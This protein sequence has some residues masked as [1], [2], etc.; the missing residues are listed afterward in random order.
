MNTREG[1]AY[2]TC[3][4]GY[5]GDTCQTEV[6]CAERPCDILGYGGA[7]IEERG[8]GA[9]GVGNGDEVGGAVGV[10]DAVSGS[11]R[12]KYRCDCSPGYSGLNCEKCAVGF[13]K[14]LFACI[15]K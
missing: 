7:C 11:K 5:K 3:S 4:N 8:G 2:C 9:V 13:A 15:P 10:G 6:T 1:L 12:R 14:S